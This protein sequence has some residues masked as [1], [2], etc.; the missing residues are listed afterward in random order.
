M[1]LSWKDGLA[2]LFVL[3][4]VV[5]LVGFAVNGSM[6]LIEDTRGLAGVGFVAGILAFAAFG[7]RA[8]GAGTLAGTAAVLAVVTIALGVVAL[9][10]ESGSWVAIA[11]FGAGILVMWGIAILHDMGHLGSA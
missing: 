9:V 7:R 2:T 5:P 4:F 3:A 10:L 11:P 8:F 6:P 1:K